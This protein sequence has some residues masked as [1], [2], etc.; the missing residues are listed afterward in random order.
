METFSGEIPGPEA[1]QYIVK[2][3]DFLSCEQDL[4][5]D[6]ICLID[7]DQSFLARSPPEKILG[8][9]VEFLAPEVA[10]GHPA[11]PASDIWALGCS[12]MRLRSGDGLFTAFDVQSPVDLTR[13]IVDIL[14]DL[15]PSWG[16]PL[17]D[18]HG[19]PTKDET[20]GVP[21]CEGF[22][23]R[24]MSKWVSDIWDKPETSEEEDNANEEENAEEEDWDRTYPYPP[25]YAHK[26]W[27]PAAIKVQGIY[28]DG[29]NDTTERVV[30]TLPKIAKA[31]VDL[32]YDLISKILVYEPTERPTA[33]ELLQ[34]PWFHIDER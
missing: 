29:Y 15:P 22:G 21:A 6:E 13:A 1:P 14:G 2:A 27:K 28:L 16:T 9:P 18:R 31:E 10:V 30:E 5:R 33:T 26:F 20:K 4:I 25:C 7:F 17:F 19:K 24:S 34:H 8:I 12:I 11:S 23:P 32:L 3:L